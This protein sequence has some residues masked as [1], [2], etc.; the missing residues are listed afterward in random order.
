MFFKDRKTEKIDCTRVN[1]LVR[2]SQNIL[3][4]LFILIIIV[5]V[6]L[7]TYL[8]KEWKIL[9]ALKTLLFVIAPVFIGLV[10]AWLFDPIVSWL[11]KKKIP[12]VLGALVVYVVL[13]GGAYLLIRLILPM[14]SDQIN[15]FVNSI[16]SILNSIKDV[17]GDF[18]E[19]LNNASHYDFSSTQN[20]IFK[21]IEEFGVGLAKQLPTMIVNFIASFLSG[22][23]TI[24]LGL[25]IGF[26]MLIDFDNVGHHLLSLIP[27]KWQTDANDLSLKLNHSLRNFVQGTLMIM[28]IVFVAQSL[29][30]TLA[31]L[32]APLLFGLFCAITNVIPYFGP[33]IG[34]IPAVIVGLSISPVT[35]FFT[36]CSIVVVQVIESFILQPIVMGKTMK[37]HPVTIMI[38]LLIFQHFFGIIGMIIATPVISGLK[39]IYQFA[40]SKIHFYKMIYKRKEKEDV[41]EEK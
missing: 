14:L 22:G 15:D 38:S 10:V 26:Y 11:K 1:E 21:T 32:K 27:K 25:M 18:F 3:R 35:G 13:L 37:L 17:I 12:R 16:P 30:L 8:L 23:M 33:Y 39:V 5:L 41:E 4:I 6:V 9:S 31:G 19:K 34:G 2:L 7:A 20:E 28:V 29:G 36:L 24:L 40:D